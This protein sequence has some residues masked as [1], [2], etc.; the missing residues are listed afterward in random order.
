METTVAHPRA[1]GPDLWR[2]LKTYEDVVR[3]IW[4]L[5]KAVAILRNDWAGGRSAKRVDERGSGAVKHRN[6]F[7]ELLGR[8]DQ[9]WSD[10]G[11]HILQE[12]CFASL[13]YLW[14][15]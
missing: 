5:E 14:N 15:S 7:G 6:G 12:I 8:I 1:Y 13:L 2:S 9:F 10:N 11:K 3:Y 4:A